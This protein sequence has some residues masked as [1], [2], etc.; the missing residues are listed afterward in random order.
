MDPETSEEA[1]ERS[2]WRAVAAWSGVG[3]EFAA[4]IVLF[5]L[6]GGW[7]DA[8]WGTHPWMRVA[9][10]SLGIVLGT[11]LVIAKALAS[12]RPDRGQPP[13]QGPLNPP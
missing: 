13:G 8:R 3:F 1:R 10:A 9:G 11:Y 5:F 12:E 2:T 7:L 4:G 6:L